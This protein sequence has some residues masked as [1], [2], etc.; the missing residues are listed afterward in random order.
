MLLCISPVS[1][2]GCA[3]CEAWA[4]V[5]HAHGLCTRC[6]F[7]GLRGGVSAGGQPPPQTQAAQ[8]PPLPL[9]LGG[10]CLILGVNLSRLWWGGVQIFHKTLFW[11]FRVFFEINVYI[12][13]LEKKKKAGCFSQCLWALANQ[14]QTWIEQKG[15]PTPNLRENSAFCAFQTGTST[16][17]GSVGS[18]SWTHLS[19]SRIVCVNSL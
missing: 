16:L 6:G 12:G 9:A 14:L 2:R 10:G 3:D 7:S 5:L 18:G 17:P 11:C 13:R 1:S 15:W 19:D 8:L 4:M